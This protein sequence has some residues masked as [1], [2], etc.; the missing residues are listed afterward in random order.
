MR[1]RQIEDS[2]LPD[3]RLTQQDQLDTAAGLGWHSGRVCHNGR[4]IMQVHDREGVVAE[5]PSSS[6]PVSTRRRSGR[7]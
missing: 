4:E 7:G 1:M 3:G 2:Y 5:L 6:V